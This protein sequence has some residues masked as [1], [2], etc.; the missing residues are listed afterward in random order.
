MR[1]LCQQSKVVI[2]SYV[3]AICG[4]GLWHAMACHPMYQY[5]QKEKGIVSLKLASSSV[6][7]VSHSHLLL[8]PHTPLRSMGAGP[9]HQLFGLHTVL[10]NFQ[11]RC[12][13]YIIFAVTQFC[14]VFG[15][16][17]SLAFGMLVRGGSPAGSFRVVSRSNSLDPIGCQGIGTPN[18]LK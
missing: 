2:P 10:F 16:S 1:L 7:F 11:E 5:W 17:P 18:C 14:I 9:N 6:F 8:E 13:G 4:Y 3:Y 12:V 15:L